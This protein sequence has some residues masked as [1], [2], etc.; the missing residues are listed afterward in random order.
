MEDEDEDDDL[1]LMEALE[2]R[3]E[4][5]EG[6]FVVDMFDWVLG[7]CAGLEGDRRILYR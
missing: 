2:E 5:M 7:A 1:D 6:L 4:K 3:R